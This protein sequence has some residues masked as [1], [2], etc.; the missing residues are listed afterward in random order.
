[1]LLAMQTLRY[2][3][4]N[5][6][7]E[8]STRSWYAHGLVTLIVASAAALLTKSLLWFG[9]VATLMFL[10]FVAKEQYDK[11]KHFKYYNEVQARDRVTYAADHAGDLIG[12]FFVALS[13]WIAYFVNW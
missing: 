9:E 10:L 4:Y 1:M 6:W 2:I 3:L 8:K 12:P 13:A 11:R 7:I 5:W